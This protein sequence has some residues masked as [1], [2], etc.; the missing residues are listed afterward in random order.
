VDWRQLLEWV[1][2]DW[3]LWLLLV[4]VLVM[5]TA[6]AITLIRE[7]SRILRVVLDYY[8]PTEGTST[9]A[10]IANSILAELSRGNFEQR[11]NGLWVVALFMYCMLVL[12]LAA[13][14]TFSLGGMPKEMPWPLRSAF[15]SILVLGILAVGCII[16]TSDRH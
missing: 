4:L 9:L 8:S 6:V 13:A 16:A 7:L 5:A 11:V 10:K 2:G 3:R 15:T 12:V 1:S 14:W